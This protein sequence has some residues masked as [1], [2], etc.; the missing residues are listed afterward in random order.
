M[1]AFVDHSFDR[2]FLLS[3]E[4]IR[5][6]HSL[7]VSRCAQL[8]PNCQP[9]Y[10]VYRADNFTY[11]TQSIDDIIKEENSDWQQ[12]VKLEAEIDNDNL[13]LSLVFDK[14]GDNGHLHIEGDD[15][16]VVFLLFSDLRQYLSNEVMTL[17]KITKIVNY[18]QAIPFLMMVIL[19]ITLAFEITAPSPPNNMEENA[20]TALQA[21]SVEE[22][23]D[24]LITTTVEERDPPAPS[25]RYFALL[26]LIAFA[27]SPFLILSG[28][29]NFIVK[30]V[31][32]LYPPNIFLIGREIERHEK[33]LRWRER[34]VWVIGIGIL[35]NVA[36]AVIYGAL[37]N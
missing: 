36:A 4:H 20:S 23:L 17:R 29:R 12:V 15:R 7:L 9:T 16:D 25:S 27:L 19:L 30:L 8:D 21:S 33:R 32:R 31:E 10:Q 1:A 35:V 22:K 3:E 34:I 11:K 14:E 24:F 26:F 6:L 2:G 28:P 18:L 37:L 5:K 13:E